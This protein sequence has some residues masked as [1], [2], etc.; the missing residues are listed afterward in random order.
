MVKKSNPNLTVVKLP[1][2]G[3]QPPRKLGPRGLALW[4]SV[5]SAY[6]INDIGG[7]E[8]LM[9]A[10]VMRD[11]SEQLAQEIERDGVTIR[12]KTGFREHPNL[13]LE[14]AA[15]AFVSRSLQKLGLN[16]ESDSI[17]SVGRPPGSW[18][19]TQR[20][21]SYDQPVFDDGDD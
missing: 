16:I 18:N 12:T 1:T 2:K 6:S 7:V 11:R 20:V 14:L 19:K 10:C 15:R 9:E 3:K 4:R 21:T 8:I 5:T 13:K 17:K